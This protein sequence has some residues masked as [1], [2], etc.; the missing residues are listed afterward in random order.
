MEELFHERKIKLDIFLQLR[1]FEQYTFE[2]E[3]GKAGTGKGEEGQSWRVL[4]P[5]HTACFL[6]KGTASGAG[7][8]ALGSTLWE[9]E[10]M[11]HQGYIFRLS[12]FPIHILPCSVPLSSPALP[13]R[14]SLFHFLCGNYFTEK[15]FDGI[16][17]T[18]G[19]L[20][21]E[22]PWHWLFELVIGCFSFRSR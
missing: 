7:K 20:L 1:I 19:T 8:G 10:G 12:K 13:S 14:A 6:V 17:W 15:V 9:F 22:R 2:V 4:G 16:I 18:L 3:V 5:L 11:V 21:P